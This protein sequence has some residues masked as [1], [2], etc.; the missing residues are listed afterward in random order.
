MEP[1]KSAEFV[2]IN[3]IIAL[4]TYLNWRIYEQKNQKSV[5]YRYL[6]E[7]TFKT[8]VKVKVTQVTWRIYLH[9]SWFSWFSNYHL[10]NVDDLVL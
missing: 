5:C 7:Q 10:R 3:V 1:P 8:N 6:S 9:F 2:Y 4:K